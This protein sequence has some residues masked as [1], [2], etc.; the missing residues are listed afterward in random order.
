MLL[1]NSSRDA[2]LAPLQAVAGVVEKRH[3]LPILSN[4]LIEKVG[5]RLTLTASDLE[6]QMRTV[7]SGQ[8]GDGD[9]AI[10]VSARKLQDILRALPDADVSL[11]VDDRRLTVKA[12][13]SRFQLQTLPAADYPVMTLPGS[14]GVQRLTVTQKAFKHLL[15]LV[16]YAMAQQDIRYYL[17]GL[18]LIADGTKLILV[19]TDGHRLAYAESTL[20]VAVS[21]KTEVILPRKTVIELGRHVSDSDDPVEIVLAGNQAVFRF[22]AVELVTKLIDGK[23][24]D[25]QQAIPQALPGVVTLERAPFAAALQR[26]AI[27]T[28]EKFRGVRLAL[29]NGLLSIISS[30]TESEEALEEIEVDYSGDRVEIGFNVGY[31]IDVLNN[32][33][34]SDIEWHF[35]DGTSSALFTLP[36]NHEFK[37]V[38]MPLR[39]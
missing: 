8:V 6:M 34:S 3:T 10:T 15:G 11:V 7:T 20:D 23:F 24:P 26:V 9:V 27:L 14:E 5:E 35:R 2:V 30:N 4:V 39:I 36:D 16:S 22:G 19:A 13:R 21:T 17:N 33:A 1:F 25:Y 37:Y 31:L 29:D 38:V 18:L 28:N 32:L 12:G